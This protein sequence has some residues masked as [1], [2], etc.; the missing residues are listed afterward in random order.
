MADVYL[1]PY[2]VSPSW[3]DDISS[4]LYTGKT[5]APNTGETDVYFSNKNSEEVICFAYNYSSSSK[6]LVFCSL[7]S[8]IDLLRGNHNLTGDTYSSTDVSYEGTYSSDYSLYYKT[9]SLSIFAPVLTVFDTLNEGL[10]ASAEYFAGGSQISVDL[11]TLSGW[12]DV[13]DGTHTLKVK[14]K[15]TGYRDSA[16]STG[17]S[18]EKAASYIYEQ[19][20]TVLKITSAPYEQQGGTLTI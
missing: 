13:S 7:S 20:G 4:F 9:V 17:V 16:L 11:T 15:A 5:L 2:I 1:V 6:R 14:A 18:F 3:P 19:T 8:Q 10:A 12:S